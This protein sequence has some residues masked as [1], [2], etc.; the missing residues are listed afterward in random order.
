MDVIPWPP[1]PPLTICISSDVPLRLYPE[2]PPSPT[3]SLT[4]GPSLACTAVTTINRP[5]LHDSFRIRA[6]RSKRAHS[7][8]ART[9][10]ATN[11]ISHKLQ[12]P[13]RVAPVG[14]VQD[15]LT[16]SIDWN[17]QA[18]RT[19]E[20]DQL[21]SCAPKMSADARTPS[22]VHS[23]ATRLAASYRNHEGASSSTMMQYHHSLAAISRNGILPPTTSPMTRTSAAA[24]LPV[25]VAPSDSTTTTC[26]SP[27]GRGCIPASAQDTTPTRGRHTSNALAMAFK[28]SQKNDFGPA[29][30]AE[31]PSQAVPPSLDILELRHP[32]PL[33]S[34]VQRDRVRSTDTDLTL[35]R[36]VSKVRHLEVR[37]L[38]ST[39]TSVGQQLTNGRVRHCATFAGA[40]FSPLASLSRATTT[41]LAA[42][43]LVAGKTPAFLELGD[44]PS[45]SH[46]ISKSLVG[47]ASFDR[48]SKN[49]GR[50]SAATYTETMA[51]SPETP[52]PASVYRGK[53]LQH[54][55][56][57]TSNTTNSDPSHCRRIAR[58]L[59]TGCVSP[60]HSGFRHSL[61]AP[62]LPSP[63]AGL[64]GPK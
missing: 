29:R 22:P 6:H 63:L 62:T 45:N 13:F 38:H 40:S 24:A 51:R 48:F 43:V 37:A 31:S 59:S 52:N 21:Y 53:S 7:S 55:K 16:L 50:P 30:H 14:D 5:S 8:P 57:L 27:R 26:A 15:D 10:S 35:S 28:L 58:V 32:S 60:L 56:I 36:F 25:P 44:Y 41:D 20:L 23:Q 19:A 33:S 49:Q 34:S 9:L 54:V 4:T 46:L 2:L 1:D 17:R 64:P 42:A 11:K 12:G 61:G 39:S 3:F 18:I 47:R